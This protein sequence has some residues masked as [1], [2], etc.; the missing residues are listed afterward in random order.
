M[1]APAG[2]RVN[3][4]VNFITFNDDELPGSAI[5][6]YRNPKS[7]ALTTGGFPHEIVLATRASS[8][9]ISKIVLVLSDAKEIVLEKG[10]TENPAAFEVMAERT[11]QRGSSGSPQTETFD[12][13]PEAA[14]RDIRFLRLTI[15]SGYS[16]FVGVYS[17]DAWGEESQQRIAIVES[18]QEVNM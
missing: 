7:F 12:V 16:E 2:P 13:D 5:V 9:K 1:A 4:E 10:T 6:D 15:V 3:L 11:L 18:K 17:I 8:A 14:G